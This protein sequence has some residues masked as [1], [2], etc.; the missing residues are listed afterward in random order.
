[1]FKVR[2]L[3]SL[4]LVAAN[5]YPLYGLVFLGLQFR[6]L[7]MIYLTETIIVLFFTFLKLYLLKRNDTKKF[8]KDFY[9]ILFIVTIFLNFVS[10]IVIT[11]NIYFKSIYEAYSSVTLTALVL[12]FLSHSISFIKNYIGNKEYIN[13]N[14]P[15]V[16]GPY[17]IKSLA[18]YL[19]MFG[20]E[21]YIFIIIIKIIVDLL[22]HNYE[23]KESDNL[24]NIKPIK[25]K[26]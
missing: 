25:T 2:Y 21:F 9:G 22:V 12:I 18:T 24:I 15:R 4:I 6:D 16:T 10:Y 19:I 1:M 3:T 14:F 23:H 8:I 5:I 11:S 20:I 26:S 13:L 17:I 7:L